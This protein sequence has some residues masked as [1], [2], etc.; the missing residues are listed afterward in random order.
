MPAAVSVPDSVEHRKVNGAVG[1][2]SQNVPAGHDAILGATNNRVR[3]EAGDIRIR[4]ERASP[5]LSETPS[6]E[7][8]PARPGRLPAV[9]AHLSMPLAWMQ[10]Q[11]GWR[12]IKS[13]TRI[14]V[15]LRS[16]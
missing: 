5:T 9:P 4:A 3:L 15:L 12:T 10:N 14:T 8:A 6:I 7:G 1:N 2:R 11:P 13:S 16:E